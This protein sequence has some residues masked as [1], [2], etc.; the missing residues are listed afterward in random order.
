M[1]NLPGVDCSFL[2]KARSLCLEAT[3]MIIESLVQMYKSPISSKTNP[4]ECVGKKY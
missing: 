4:K 1:W 2:G 3:R